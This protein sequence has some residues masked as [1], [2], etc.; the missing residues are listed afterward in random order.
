M[1]IGL[2]GS[3][4]S[5]ILLAPYGDPDWK[6]FGCSPGAAFSVKRADVWFEIHKIDISNPLDPIV[7]K[8]Y[9]AWL[10]NFKGPVYTIDQIPEIP[11]SVRYPKEEMLRKYGPFFFYSSLSWMFALALEQNPEEIGIW[12]VDMSAG[13]EYEHQRPAMH[14]FIQIALDRGIKITVPPQSQLLYPPALYGYVEV[15]AYVQ[16]QRARAL[17]LE[18]KIR[19]HEAQFEHHKTQWLF[20]KGARDNHTNQEQTFAGYVHALEERVKE[21][22][23]RISQNDSSQKIS[24]PAGCITPEVSAYVQQGW[25]SRHDHGGNGD[26]RVSDG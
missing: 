23:A 11:T 6:L 3:H 4:P 5:S 12:G 7:T 1:K 10:A 9:L 21:L 25:Q 18:Q 20:L 17:T 8:D 19:D 24:P 26:A 2:I 14:H 16:Q 15:S 13:E 22:E